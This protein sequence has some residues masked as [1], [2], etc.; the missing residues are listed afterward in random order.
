[1]ETSTYIKN[2]RK[3][4]GLTQNQLAEI[5]KTKRYNIANYETGRAI[6]PGTIILAIQKMLEKNN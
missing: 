1:M 3:N 2:A 6:P 4:L 5:L